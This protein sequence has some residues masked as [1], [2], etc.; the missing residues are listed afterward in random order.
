MSKTCDF[1]EAA[2]A[3]ACRAVAAW[4]ADVGWLREPDGESEPAYTGTNWSMAL[5]QAHFEMLSAAGRIAGT[6]HTAA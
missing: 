4:I 5:C 1:K 3:P 6:P 2:G